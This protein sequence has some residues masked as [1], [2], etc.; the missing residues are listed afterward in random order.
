MEY[1]GAGTAFREPLPCNGLEKDGAG[2][3]F[4]VPLPDGT[5]F[6]D[7]LCAI[8]EIGA[9]QRTMTKLKR[10]NIKQT[11][12]RFEQEFKNV[13]SHLV[14]TVFDLTCTLAR[15]MFASASLAAKSV[16]GNH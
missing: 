13:K 8:A 12:I 16:H 5:A 4:R 3:T 2:T 10:H 1:D 14:Q 15:R 6:R 11:P 7:P 9:R